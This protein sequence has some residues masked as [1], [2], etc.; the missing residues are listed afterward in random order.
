[1][2]KAPKPLTRLGATQS[3][4]AI[5]AALLASFAFHAPWIA[6]AQASKP[7]P[8]THRRAIGFVNPDDQR[9]KMLVELK[10]IATKLDALASKVDKPM[11]VR[12]I[13][14]PASAGD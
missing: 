3:L 1:M 5:N 11:D 8:V 6:P 12:V 13:E 9:Q 7:D 2:S 4:L 10:R 14:M